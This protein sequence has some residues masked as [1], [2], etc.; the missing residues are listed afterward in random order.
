MCGARTYENVFARYNPFETVNLAGNAEYR[1]TLTQL[2]SV[3]YD[4]MER[5]RDGGLIPEP[6]LE[7]MG[8]QYGNKH[9][10]LNQPANMGLVRE[11]IA[12]IESGEHGE[13]DKLVAALR[14]ERASIRYW[15]ATWL[16]NLKDPSLASH[17]TMLIDDENPTVRVAAA[18]ALANLGEPARYV[19]LLAEHINSAN[20]IT[21]MYAIT[22]LEQLG[23][24]AKTAL[25]AIHTARENPYEFTRRI[26]RRLAR[27]LS[28]DS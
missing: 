4:W 12:V 15:A 17:L 1:Q 22:A 21:G 6:I 3:V 16:G 11:L 18:H 25:P 5:T 27:K 20:L 14:S 10:V 26:A 8:C 9:H 13:R 28:N 2:R 23:Q 19:P 24:T 7:D